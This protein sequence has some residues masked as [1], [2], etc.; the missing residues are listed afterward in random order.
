MGNVLQIR[1]VTTKSKTTGF[2][3]FEVDNMQLTYL[4]SELVNNPLPVKKLSLTMK[5]IAYEQPEYHFEKSTLQF[6]RVKYQ[7]IQTML[8]NLEV[9]RKYENYD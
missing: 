6:A 5:K 4:D 8:T 9:L 3:N 7:S 2:V 1:T